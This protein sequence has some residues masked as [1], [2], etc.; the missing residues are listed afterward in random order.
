MRLI[1][2]KIRKI[3]KTIKRKLK[4]IMYPSRDANLAAKVLGFALSPYRDNP[5]L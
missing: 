5:A 4:Q 1:Q 3:N 2:I